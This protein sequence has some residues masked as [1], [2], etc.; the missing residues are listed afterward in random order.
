MKKKSLPYV[1]S[2]YHYFSIWVFFF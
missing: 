1:L 2:N